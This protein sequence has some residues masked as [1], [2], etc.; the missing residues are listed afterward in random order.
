MLTMKVLRKVAEPNFYGAIGLDGPRPLTASLLNTFPVSIPVQTGD[1]LDLD[2]ATGVTGCTQTGVLG[3][4]LLI[5]PGYLNVGDAGSFSS[6]SGAR[7]NVSAVLAPTNTVTLGTTTFD[8]KKGSATLSLTL[9]NPG[10]L[11]ASGSGVKALI[12]TGA[13]IPTSL[14]AGPLQL[15]IKAQGKKKKQLKSAGKAKLTVALSF[16]PVN[17]DAATQTTQVKL[18]KK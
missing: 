15:L 17:G 12:P 6:S 14:P 1:I 5:K 2:A 13:P 4:N 3:D 9:P 16:T 7:I 10:A 8:K 11:T 18:K